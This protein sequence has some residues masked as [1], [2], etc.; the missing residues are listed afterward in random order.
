MANCPKCWAKK[1][2]FSERCP[3]CNSNV[4]IEDTWNTTTGL[5]GLRVLRNLF[6]IAII[7]IIVGP[8]F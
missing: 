3:H 4:T 2:L 1:P 5:F 7:A 6:I 8:Y